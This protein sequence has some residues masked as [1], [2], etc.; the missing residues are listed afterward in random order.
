MANLD[1]L[2]NIPV[3]RLDNKSHQKGHDGV[4][5]MYENLMLNHMK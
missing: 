5:S 1:K 4:T 3:D 2:C